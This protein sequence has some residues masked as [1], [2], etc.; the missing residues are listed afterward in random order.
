LCHTGE[1]PSGEL[2]GTLVIPTSSVHR[3]AKTFG[4]DIR[5]ERTGAQVGRQAAEQ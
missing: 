2:R 4:I 3:Y 5:R 1:L